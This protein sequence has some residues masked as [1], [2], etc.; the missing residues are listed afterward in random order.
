MWFYAC[1]HPLVALADFVVPPIEEVVGNEVKP[2]C[3]SLLQTIIKDP[4]LHHNC[5][6]HNA[7][8][9]YTFCPIIPNDNYHNGCNI[10]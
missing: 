1:A 10:K 2:F 5:V 9:I 4:I 3:V 8:I 7:Y 6:E